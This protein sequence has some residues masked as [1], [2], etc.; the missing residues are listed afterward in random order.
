MAHERA[1]IEAAIQR[2][3]ELR[4]AAIAGD[5]PWSALKEVFTDDA[6][7]IDSVWGRH[8][9]VDALVEFLDNSM[10]G[11]ESWDF[12]HFWEAIDGD[13]VFLR[14]SNRLPG[15]LPDGSPIDNFGLS[16]LEYAGSGKFSRRGGHVLRESPPRGDEAVHLGADRRHGGPARRPR[17]GVASP[18]MIRHT[19]LLT[20]DGVDESTR[21]DGHRRT[22]QQMPSLI[23]EIQAYTVGRDLGLGDGPPMVV[24]SGDFATVADYQ[25]YSGHPEHVRVLDDH[26]RPHVTAL[27]RA[28][29]ELP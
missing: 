11:L 1:E 17:L 26:I 7:F 14:W 8:Q 12:P 5:I 9:G 29:I 24:V 28:Q 2:Y 3:L 15:E 20:F 4:R 13:R 19:V 23:P 16:Y 22:P 6:V 18:P 25:T 10:A 21:P 27:A